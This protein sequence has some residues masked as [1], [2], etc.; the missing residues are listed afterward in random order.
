[1]KQ[2]IRYTPPSED[3]IRAFPYA[4]ALTAASGKNEDLALSEQA[5]ALAEEL[6][7]LYIPRRNRSIAELKAENQCEYILILG[8]NGRLFMDQPELIWH[9]NMAMIRLRS[10]QQGKKD[11]FLEAAGINPGD[12]V[13]DC[14]LGLASDALIAAW[15]AGPRG[16]VTGLE[17]SPLISTITAWGLAKQ[18]AQYDS[19]KVQLSA[20]A[21]Q[22]DVRCVPALDF[23]QQQPDCSWDQVYF[24]PMFKAAVERS[25]GMNQIRPLACYDPFDEAVLSEAYRVC[26]KAIILKER[27]F[28][29]LFGRLNCPKVY[30]SKYGPIA[31]GIWGKE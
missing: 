5:Q 9:P 26:R 19:R 21:G 22:I 4:Y 17:A 11:L 13:L 3:T 14:T 30:Q 25:S 24:D 7:C 18:S 28:S 1:M 20:I 12:R 10:L 2:L 29:K 23:L 15:A 31:Y 6:G 27:V 8:R 16:K